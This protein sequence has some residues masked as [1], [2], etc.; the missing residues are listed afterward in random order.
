MLDH[1]ALPGVGDPVAMH[2]IDPAL[3]KAQVIA[4]GFQYV[5]ESN[6]LAN[7]ADPHNVG[8]RDPA[9]RARPTSSS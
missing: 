1:K 2:R 8:V 5:G 9:F 6:A 3:V 7:P 4:A